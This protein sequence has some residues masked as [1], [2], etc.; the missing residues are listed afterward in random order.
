[1]TPSN[2]SKYGNIKEE[3][4]G[5]TFDSRK[6]AARYR[7]LRLLEQAGEIH[8][9]EVHPK[10]ELWAWVGTVV[11]ERRVIGTYTP[12]F[13]YQTHPFLGRTIIEDVKGVRTAVYRLKKK[14]FEANY[15]LKITEV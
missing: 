3:V 13:E 12:D 9:L 8:D 7:E 11:E 14:L 6:E 10:Y 15:G 4:D 1:M 5:Y 2:K